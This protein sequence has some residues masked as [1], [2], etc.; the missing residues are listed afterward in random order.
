[1]F[2]FT[3]FFSARSNAFEKILLRDSVIGFDVVGANTRAY[4]HK[5]ISDAIRN[6]VLRNHS[7][8]INNR[9][10]ESRCP[11]L[12]IANTRG[13]RFLAGGQLG[14]IVPKCVVKIMT[15][16]FGFRHSFVI[17]HSSFVIHI[18]C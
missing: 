5:L 7:G 12:Q 1:M 14:R 13:A 10:T 6:R 16:P 17:R 3:R 11:F 15:R 9:F 8:K 2:C 4:S 18:M